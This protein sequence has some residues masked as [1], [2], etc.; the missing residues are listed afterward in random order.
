VRNSSIFHIAFVAHKQDHYVRVC[1]LLQLSEP[2]VDVQEG[3]MLGDVVDQQR[4]HCVPVVG[5]GNGSIA[6]LSS[7]V[8]NLCSD[9]LLL[10]FETPSCELHSY[11]RLGL[12]FELV[13]G[14]PEKQV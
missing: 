4:P 2:P 3:L 6:L 10:H 1:V 7:C 13:L 12:E 14:V 11:S 8:P 9:R 5:I